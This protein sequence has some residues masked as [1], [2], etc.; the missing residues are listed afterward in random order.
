MT[1]R[2]V[3]RF[4]RELARAHPGPVRLILAGGAAAAVYGHDRPTVDVDFEVGPP[5]GAVR[6]ERWMRSFEAALRR[7]AAASG[8]SP[9]WTLD[10]SRWS[11]VAL[12]HHR[13]R[14]RTWKR[15]GRTTVC[16]LDPVT[17]VVS[18]LRRGL[19]WD[20]EDVRAVIG[21]RRLGWR[22]MAVRCG[23]A[24]AASPF[25]AERP[26][27]KSRVE[28]FLRQDGPALWRRGYAAAAAIRLFRTSAGLGRQKA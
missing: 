4:A 1:P 21:K 17:F 23:E 11:E 22:I 24:F 9:Q 5:P 28:Q 18:K 8:A 26:L 2:D 16:V 19:A 3:E 20:L 25:S 7:A 6:N 14:I 13:R 12:P 15:F 27:F 10:L